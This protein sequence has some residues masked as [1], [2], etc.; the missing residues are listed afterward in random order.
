MTSQT[1][2]PIRSQSSASWLTR[3]MLTLRKTFSRSFASS[4]ASGDESSM[5]L[6]LMRRRSAA[7]RLVA[8]GVVAADQARHA[9]RGAGRVAGV[10]PLRREGE[11]EVA[12]GDEPGSLE[13]LAERPGRR[14]REGR[15]LEDDEL[16]RAEVLADQRRGAQH[17]PE[18]R[19]LRAGDRRRDADE[20]DVGL[21]EAG[22][23]PARRPA[24]RRRARPRAGRS[25]CR[26]SAS[27]RR[28]APSTRGAWASMPST[29]RPASTN[30]IASGRPT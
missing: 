7:A 28:P 19:V 4:A 27:G 10:D 15:R 18:V 11:V 9:L 29:S 1:S 12:A 25:G 2:R 21:G 30:A 13:L 5:T 6:S 3:A 14:A 23:R 17:R 20:D 26:R 22:A 16:A 8:A 24:G